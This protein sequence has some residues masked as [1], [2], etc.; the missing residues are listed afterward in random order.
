MLLED[1]LEPADMAFG[2]ARDGF[3]ALLRLG[4]VA[5]SIMS[6]APSWI[7]FSA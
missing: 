5:F 4:S 3:A 6:A 7:C 1:L 2:L